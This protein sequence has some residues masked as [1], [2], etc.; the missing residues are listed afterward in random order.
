MPALSDV[1]VKTQ[2]QMTFSSFST[3][4]RR[5]PIISIYISISISIYLYLYLYIYI[6]SKTAHSDQWPLPVE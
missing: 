6:S 5:Y 4:G 3:Y 2:I 1:I